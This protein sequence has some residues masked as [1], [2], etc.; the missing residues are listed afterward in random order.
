MFQKYVIFLS[1]KIFKYIFCCKPLEICR[2]DRNDG[3]SSVP[4]LQN[5]SGDAG[6]TTSIAA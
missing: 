5:I 6:N 2:F 1:D 3:C 4:G